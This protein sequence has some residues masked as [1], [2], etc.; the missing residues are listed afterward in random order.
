[1]YNLIDTSII[2][3]RSFGIML[4]TIF[5][6]LFVIGTLSL[7]LD[8]V[9]YHIKNKQYDKN[10]KNPDKTKTFDNDLSKEDYS[11]DYVDFF[12]K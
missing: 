9:V 3:T 5:L 12:E 6:S 11:V 1:M 4:I 7:I 2:D 8:S 10:I